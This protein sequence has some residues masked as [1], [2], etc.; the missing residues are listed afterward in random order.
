MFYKILLA[1][2]AMVAAVVVYF[3]VV[4]LGDG[5]ISSFNIELWLTILVALAVVIGG[6][7]LLNSSG[8]RRAA[9]ALLLV[10]ATP[11]CLYALFV[12]SLVIFQPRW[13]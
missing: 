8:Y 4:G 12:L 3:F 10:L 5:S 2:D 13:N 11:A 7:V 9:N 6:G 1:I